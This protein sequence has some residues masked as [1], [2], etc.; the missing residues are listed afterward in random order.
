M[1]RSRYM[2]VLF[3]HD[4]I[5][6]LIQSLEMFSRAKVSKTIKL[7]EMHGNQIGM[8][9]SKCIAPGLFELRIRGVQEVR[10]FYVFRNNEAIILHGF[11]KKKGTL[12]LKELWLVLKR[13]KI[14][15]KI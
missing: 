7:L 10:L 13:K 11:I 9:H 5:E 3:F 1:E 2:H 4:D 14:F 12:P 15:D 6:K 8:P